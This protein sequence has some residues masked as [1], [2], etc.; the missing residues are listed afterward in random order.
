MIQYINWFYLK[1]H[2]HFYNVM[3]LGIQNYLYVNSSQIFHS[4]LEDGQTASLLIEWNYFV[5][6]LIQ[7][8]FVKRFPVLTTLSW[9]VK[10]N[11]FKYL[12]VTVTI[13]MYIVQN[14]Y[15]FYNFK[16]ILQFSNCYDFYLNHLRGRLRP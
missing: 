10:T 4:H 15:L 11:F 5:L 7:M 1:C 9:W 2:S 12:N 3:K 16:K 14:K 8:T 13:C 6:A